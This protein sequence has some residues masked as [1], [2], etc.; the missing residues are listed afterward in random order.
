MGTYYGK[1]LEVFKRK[2]DN[3]LIPINGGVSGL[4]FTDGEIFK[5]IEN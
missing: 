5:L 1:I 4:K 2:G 3:L